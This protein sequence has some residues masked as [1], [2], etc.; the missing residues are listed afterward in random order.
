MDVLVVTPFLR[1]ARGLS[2]ELERLSGGGG[3]YLLGLHHPGAQTIRVGRL[4]VFQFAPGWYGYAGSALGGARARLAR[5][6]RATKALH[7]HIDYLAAHAHPD[8]AWVS[9]SPMHLECAWARSL[10]GL[11][12]ARLWPPHFGATDCRCPGHLVWLAQAPDPDAV[13]ELLAP[14]LAR[15]T[16]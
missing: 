9:L 4:G 13:S 2:V 15:P 1:G 14:T 12:G 10:C 6:L 11:P 3:T 5:H 7:W 16:A 8:R